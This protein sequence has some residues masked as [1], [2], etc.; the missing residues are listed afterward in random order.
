M[1]ETSDDEGS[2]TF[3]PFLF[4]PGRQILA[5]SEEQVRLGSRAASILQVLVANPGRLISKDELI[6]HAWPNTT[7]EEAN[8]KV[9]ICALRR[10]LGD[11]RRSTNYIA[12]VPGRGY[13]FIA[14]VLMTSATNATGSYG[15]GASGK[16]L[17]VEVAIIGRDAEIADVGASLSSTRVVTL[18]GPVGVGKA[19]VA[20]AAAAS[21][22]DRYDDGSYV[23]DFAGLT[24]ASAVPNFV[25]AA[26]GLRSKSTD[27]TGALLEFLEHRKA[28]IVM[29]HCEK[30][31]DGVRLLASRFLASDSRSAIVAISLEPLRV[32]GEAVHRIG[33]L[34]YPAATSKMDLDREQA[35]AF[36]AVRMF[37]E[38]SEAKTGTTL[39]DT[40]IRL[41]IR[42]CQIMDGR[43]RSIAGALSDLLGTFSYF[44]M[45]ERVYQ[46]VNFGPQGGEAEDLM[47]LASGKTDF[48]YARLS[49]DEA[50]LLRLLSVFSSAFTLEDTIKMLG[51]TGWDAHHAFMV[52]SSLIAKSLVWVEPTAN[53]VAY[54][55]LAAERLFA[56]KRLRKAAVELEHARRQ[57]AQVI[58]GVF[59]QAQVE[60]SWSEPGAWQAKYLNRSEDLIDAI[61]WAAGYGREPALQLE[62]TALGIRLWNE[63]SDLGSRR[64][65]L[66]R[67]LRFGQGVP[68]LADG[69]AKV[70]TSY[71][72]SLTHASR[73]GDETDRCWKDAIGYAEKSGDGGNHFSAL[74][75][76][77]TYLF[78]AGR[79]N[80][81]GAQ[82]PKLEEAASR[83]GDHV[84]DL[85]V[86]RLK[87]FVA[88][89]RGEV[90][91]ARRMLSDV[92]RQ[93]R[94]DSPAPAAQRFRW[95]RYVTIHSNLALLDFISD[96]EGR[97][98]P[99]IVRIEGAM[100]ERHPQSQAMFL[101]MAALPIAYWRRDQTELQRLLTTFAL[102]RGTEKAELWEPVIDFYEAVS[103][104]MARL[105]GSFDRMVLLLE[106]LLATGFRRRSSLYLSMVAEAAIELGRKD[107]AVAMIG[108]ALERQER[109][110]E[111]W[112]MP[113]IMRIAAKIAMLT[114]DVSTGQRRMEEAAEHAARMETGFFSSRIAE[115]LG[116]MFDGGGKRRGP[117]VRKAGR[118]ATAPSLITET[119]TI[120]IG[121]LQRIP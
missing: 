8:L 54:R 98:S 113:E 61:E 5:R 95:E 77:C 49:D 12:T 68:S 52:L 117:T 76:Y 30:V 75:G 118:I 91:E 65:Y 35:L 43:P 119:S 86:R 106:E 55:L 16:G 28:L 94:I 20:R 38:R 3:G 21:V 13:Q 60:W 121:P 108:Q 104:Y 115:D 33:P 46:R 31:T 19:S 25:A 51:P 88:L 93:L 48:G 18:A 67:A 34:T 72:W 6:A 32:A 47:C 24:D 57:H 50:A 101:T 22:L 66:E 59:R 83:V 87:S 69:M 85:D 84:F 107:V 7:V 78:V 39:T 92:A 40:E 97:P 109:C 14:P 64:G 11:T 89:D 81:V 99:T 100:R 82:L 10:A 26:M 45:V 58:L 96:G 71:A 79:S 111:A 120:D 114:G 42:M 90:A 4:R 41:I 44:E 105:P 112:Y 74:F 37:V 73:I 63:Q 2:F 70:A 29:D 116:S 27:M 17:P 1:D 103:E 110:E 102:Y 15:I 62:L 36:S 80:E 53:I 9:H 56:R 23:V